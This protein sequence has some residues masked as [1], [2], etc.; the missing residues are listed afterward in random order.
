MVRSAHAP[1]ECRQL[2]FPTT[3]RG[4]KSQR[5][6]EPEDA[7]KL[8]VKWR[9]T[10]TKG[11]QSRPTPSL[12]IV[13]QIDRIAYMTLFGSL[14]RNTTGSAFETDEFCDKDEG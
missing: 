14:Y 7:D 10:T 1:G 5:L 3:A 9:W 12:R 6:Y 8:C 4:G 13:E 2:M 11:Y